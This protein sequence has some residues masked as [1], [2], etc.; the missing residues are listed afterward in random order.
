MSDSLETVLAASDQW[1]DETFP[2]STDA[3]K[4]AH[5]REEFAE[6]LDRPTNGE[7]LA[8]V[9][10]I[11]SHL[12]GAAE[13]SVLVWAIRARRIVDVQGEVERKLGICR[14]RIWGEPDA[15]GKVKALV[16]APVEQALGRKSWDAYWFDVARLVSTRA[17]CP[18][19]SI[20]AVLVRFQR[21]IATGYNGAPEGE[22]HCPS[23]GP[24]LAEHLALITCDRSVHAEINTLRNSFTSPYGSTLYVCGPRKICPKCTDHLK[25]QGVT[26]IRWSAR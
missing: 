26:D 2:R 1:A 15:D 14:Q 8:D 7:E 21:I 6:L 22:K 9:L 19:A 17:T 12:F 18:R 11:L 23:S 20:G 10:M 24:E 3:A 5:L 25:A 13:I 16:K 4:I